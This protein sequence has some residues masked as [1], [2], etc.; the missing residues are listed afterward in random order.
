VQYVYQLHGLR[1]ASEFDLPQIA[2]RQAPP[3]LPV[4]VLV[5]TGSIAD[6][7]GVVS[8]GE[9]V[10]ADA[11]S[12]LMT[13]PGVGYLANAGHEVVVDAEPDADLTL[14]RLYL[15]G[16]VL[17]M[18]CHQRGLF[19]L[20]ASAVAFGGRAIAFAGEQ[21]AG[22]STLAAHCIEGGAQLVADDVLALTLAADGS[23]LAHPGVPYLRLWSQSLKSLRRRGG[24]DPVRD[25]WRADK[26]QVA[27]DA[28]AH[29]PV[30]LEGIYILEGDRG[31][32]LV[33]PLRGALAVAALASQSYRVEYVD[34]IG[35]RGDHFLR[36]ATFAAAVE[37]AALARPRG[38]DRLPDLARTFAAMAEV[39]RVPPGGG[40]QTS[41]E[42]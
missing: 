4:D 38:L 32:R 7:A 14:M 3:G 15:L 6:R 20:H 24:A 35:K 16:S 18:I 8:Q 9:F 30:P 37:V 22:K 25:W 31:T 34:L 27:C 42:A 21:G 2:L 26:F 29:R 19:L 12:A 39:P 13:V 41:I 23:V 5:H 17:G 10:R 33:A 11:E 1:L 36:A 40:R 28:V